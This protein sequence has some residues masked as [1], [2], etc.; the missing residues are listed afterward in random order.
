MDPKRVVEKHLRAADSGDL[1]AWTA[2]QTSDCEFV[3]PGATLR[4]PDQSR[5]YLH[6]FLLAMPG[7]RHVVKDVFVSG[8]SV[9]VEGMIEGAHTGPLLTPRGEIPP[10]GKAFLVR[11]SAV[12]QVVGERVASIHVYFDQMELLGQ[13]GALPG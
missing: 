3:A 6:T 5:S 8:T 2:T 7:M 11:F 9:T 10:T 12:Y 4:G 13:L 1:D